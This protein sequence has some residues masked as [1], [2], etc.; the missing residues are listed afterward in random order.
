MQKSLT[1]FNVD[2]MP[3]R[4]TQIAIEYA[5]RVRVKSPDTPVFWVHA[6]N[7]SR[8][9]LTYRAIAAAANLPGADDPKTD[10]LNMVLRW[11]E[12]G[13][14]RR[15]EAEEL[16]V[17]VMETSLR[18]LGQEHPDTLT[19]MNNLAFTWRT[20]GRDNEAWKL[21][22]ECFLLRKLKLGADHPDTVSSLTTLH[23]WQ[24][25]SLEDF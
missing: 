15:K 12:N 10:I 19:S 25:G 6:S 14:N 20:Q 9:E 2:L 3:D 4:K 21:M 18:V 13:I 8:I 5:Y 11:L 7:A 22:E 23:E 17:Q 16:E 1:G 24:T